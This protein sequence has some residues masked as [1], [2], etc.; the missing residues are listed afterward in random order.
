MR[1]YQREPVVDTLR[2]RGERLKRGV[3]KAIELHG[4]QG[5]F[6]VT[7]QP[8]CL[9]FATR[10]E[11]GKPS[12]AFRALF[13]QEMIKR[14]ILGPSFVVSYSH[15]EADIDRTIEAVE[16]SLGIYKK[17]LENGVPNYLTGRPLKP[18]YRPFN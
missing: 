11:Q 7:G 10:D 9:G 15:E 17:A 1:I 2:K 3:E 13:M 18:V 14:G 4:L 8:C 5:R 12:Q 6:A 16:G